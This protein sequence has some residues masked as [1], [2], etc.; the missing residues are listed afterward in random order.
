MEGKSVEP[1]ILELG[2]QRGQQL[3]AYLD[4]LLVFLY[5]ITR[6]GVVQCVDLPTLQVSATG[7][8]PCVTLVSAMRTAASAPRY[9]ATLWPC[10]Y[11]VIKE[12]VSDYSS[13]LEDLRL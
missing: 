7:Q 3:R 6:V 11:S 12:K 2:K 4:G 8:M 1:G 13:S 5:C 10:L 9:T